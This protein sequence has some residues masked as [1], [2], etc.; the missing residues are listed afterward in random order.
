MRGGS[1]W[2][3]YGIG[4][5]SLLL[6]VDFYVDWPFKMQGRH[7]KRTGNSIGWSMIRNLSSVTTERLDR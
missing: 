2:I 5:I 1:K 7:L 4:W 6:V 3:V